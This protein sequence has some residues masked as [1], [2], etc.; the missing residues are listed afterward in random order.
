VK[1]STSL[2]FFGEVVNPLLVGSLG[3]KFGR[4]RMV[5]IFFIFGF[6][7][8]LFSLLSAFPN[9]YGVFAFFRFIVGFCLGRYIKLKPYLYEGLRI[10]KMCHT[11]FLHTL[12]YIFA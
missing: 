2:I 6:L 5:Y 12:L 1:I 8:A 10:I 3:D 4:K 7:T 11:F 9:I